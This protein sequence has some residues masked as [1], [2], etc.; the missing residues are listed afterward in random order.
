MRKVTIL[1]Y[2]SPLTLTPPTSLW[3]PTNHMG[4]TGLRPHPPS[5]KKLH[6]L[7]EHARA[8]GTR[9]LSGC[10]SSPRDLAVCGKVTVTKDY[11]NHRTLL[12]EGVVTIVSTS[13]GQSTLLLG[14]AVEISSQSRRAQIEMVKARLTIL[15]VGS[16]ILLCF[17]R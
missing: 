7:H 12:M 1:L 3:I 11:H 8:A 2:L 16:N 14:H 5:G 15:F 9:Q 17:R 4:L 13:R 10:S 6:R